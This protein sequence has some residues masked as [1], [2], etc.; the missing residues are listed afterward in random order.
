MNIIS[1]NILDT[2]LLDNKKA[3]LG[4]PVVPVQHQE[5]LP[6]VGRVSRVVVLARN[7]VVPED[8]EVGLVLV[9]HC[10]DV[11]AVNELSQVVGCVHVEFYKRSQKNLL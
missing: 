8:V 5:V 10:L 7:R 11:E 4:C 6:V 2:R 9:H 1:F 3:N